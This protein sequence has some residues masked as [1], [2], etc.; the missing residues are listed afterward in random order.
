MLEV[1]KEVCN[2]TD[3]FDC[4][5]LQNFSQFNKALANDPKSS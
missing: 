3:H 5:L 2:L 1:D 4:G